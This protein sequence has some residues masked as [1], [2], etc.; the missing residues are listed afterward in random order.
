MSKI[1]PLNITAAT[2]ATDETT[3]SFTLLEKI[4][5]EN[6]TTKLHGLFTNL[7]VTATESD[8]AS[9]A[10]NVLYELKIG[11]TTVLKKNSGDQLKG[12]IIDL[13][14]DG[15][16]E[17]G[18]NHIGQGPCVLVATLDTAPALTHTVD[19]AVFGAVIADGA[20]NDNEYN[21]WV[22]RASIDQEQGPV[23]Q[24]YLGQPTG[25]S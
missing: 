5:R 17:L 24:N 21:G 4:T 11:G 19:I 2:I 16:P 22:D 18:V 8:A 20:P 10:A 13:I 3:A 6:A 12:E 1:Q 7:Q 14:K 23:S 15:K 9:A 25:F